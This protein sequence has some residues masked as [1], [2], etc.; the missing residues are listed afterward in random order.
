MGWPG[1]CRD[2]LV[3]NCNDSGVGSLRNVATQASSGDVIDMTRLACGKIALQRAIALPQ[4]DGGSMTVDNSLIHNNRGS[5]GGGLHGGLR[6]V[7]R[8]STISGNVAVNQAGGIYGATEETRIINST[9]SGNSAYEA[10]AAYLRPYT[11]V[12]G[13]TIAFN[14]SR[15]DDECSAAVTMFRDSLLVSSIL[16]R[17][18]CLGGPPVDL[19]VV[20]F[21][22]GAVS[23]GHNLIGAANGPVPGDTI[24][25]DPRL[26]PL[27]DNGGPTP[28]HLPAVGSPAIDKGA[29]LLS[30]DYDQRGPGF[31]RVQPGLADIGAV[32][33]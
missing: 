31:P 30:Q 26:G 33:R 24:S 21:G 11:F 14:E 18:T 27:A 17:N 15:R 5:T 25:G 19:Q 1:R 3:A 32:E 13:S 7:V 22:T 2:P 16:A 9:I 29:N 6:L 10:G 23:G 12:V 4:D 28:T 20:D 8:N